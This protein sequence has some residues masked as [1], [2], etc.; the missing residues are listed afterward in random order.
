MIDDQLVNDFMES[1]DNNYPQSASWFVSPPPT[2]QYEP[3][4]AFD[5]NVFY[6]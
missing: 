1:F 5:A 6:G 3:A 2:D 4:M